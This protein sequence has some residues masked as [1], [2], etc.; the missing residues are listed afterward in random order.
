[1]G[2]IKTAAQWRPLYN[3]RVTAP[4]SPSLYLRDWPVAAPRHAVLLVHG[5]GEHSG[6]YDA[7]AQWFN[8]RGYAVRAYDH[9]GHGQSPGARG[10]LRRSAVLL[11]DLARVFAQYR[12]ELGFT[13]LLLGHSMG[14][15]VCAR[16]VTAGRVTPSGLIL[17][18][19]ALRPRAP[20]YL[21]NLARVLA[22]AVPHKAL[23]PRTPS[24]KL[25]HDPAVHDRFVADPLRHGRIT[26]RLA[27]FIV[28][29][30]RA[31]IRDAR[32]LSV[33]TLLLAAGDDDL[34]DPSG[35]LEFAFRAPPD[36]I[37]FQ[38]FDELYHELFNEAEPA[39]S[40]VLGAVDAWLWRQPLPSSVPL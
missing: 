30:G 31:A 32:K 27:A 9:W 2:A 19:P 26:P 13:P 15:A 16:A 17:S 34:V 28:S 4:T 37:T 11:D 23:P 29:A 25:S 35:S 40:A 38:Y 24:L 22:L 20:R 18:S 1:M 21:Q 14:G 6:R 3:A 10:S 33:P 36:L 5:L 8:A 7:L 39:R 12:A